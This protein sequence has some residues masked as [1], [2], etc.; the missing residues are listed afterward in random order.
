[1]DRDFA[2]KSQMKGETGRDKERFCRDTG[3]K[4]RLSGENRKSSRRKQLCW[5]LAPHR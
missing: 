1:M 2:E 4:E 3:L 5:D